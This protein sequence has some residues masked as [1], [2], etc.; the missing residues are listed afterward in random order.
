MIKVKKSTKKITT[1]DLYENPQD[2]DQR[3]IRG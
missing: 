3:I 2:Y 1:F